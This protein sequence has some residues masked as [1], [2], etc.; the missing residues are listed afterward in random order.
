MTCRLL[1]VAALLA[2]SI[3][4]PDLQA[5]DPTFQP[6]RCEIIPLPGHQVSFQI[7]GVEKSRWHY[8]Q[9]Y[10]RPFFYPFN[11]PSGV[12]LTRMGHPGAQNHDH[13][14]SVWFAHAKLNGVDFWSDN[15]KARVRQKWWYAYLDGNNE[16]VMA[17]LTGWFHG[18]GNELMEQ[19]VVAAL[20]P[21]KDGE[22]ALE[23][24][25]T[26]RPSA[27][28]A[29]VELEQT[30]FGFLAVR[31]AKT[32]SAHFGGGTISNSEGQVDEPNIFGKPARWMDYSGPIVAGTGK[33]RKTVIEG[34]TYFDHPTNPRYPTRWHLRE[35]GW[36]GAS[37]G[38]KEAFTITKDKPLQLRY[39]LHAHSGAYDHDAANAVHESFVKRPGFE[40][41]KSTRK[42]RQYEVRRVVLKR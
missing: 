39:L 38:M 34:I 35:D 13:H 33:D 19:D 30:N 25:I 2:A 12:S 3:L 21:M 14:R 41:I 37:F 18:D 7:D 40:V 1:F 27:N 9:Q 36:M 42:H 24:H 22:H 31:V 29:Q 17:S 20:I 16:C 6:S 10:P 28:V 15:T 11:G 4:A 5:D 26:M 32:L 8:G 23:I